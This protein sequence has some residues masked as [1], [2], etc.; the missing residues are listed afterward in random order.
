M[1]TWVGKTHEIKI[2]KQCYYCYFLIVDKVS[3]IDL[4]LFTSIDQQLI[5]ARRISSNSTLVFSGLSLVVLMDDFYQFALIQ[6]KILW[7]NSIEEKE[8]YRKSFCSKFTL[9]L[10]LTEQIYQKTDLLF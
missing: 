7:V 2:N 9:I 6:E 5:K 1:N 8:V 3:I 4:K 10:I